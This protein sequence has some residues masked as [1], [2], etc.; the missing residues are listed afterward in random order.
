MRKISHYFFNAQYKKKFSQV[1]I[2]LIAQV[3]SNSENNPLYAIL[4]EDMRLQNCGIKF[5]RK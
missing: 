2:L 1:T 5:I 4:H 3:I